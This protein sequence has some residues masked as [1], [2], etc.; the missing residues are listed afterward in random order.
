MP[1]RSVLGAHRLVAFAATA[2]PAKAKAFYKDTLGLRL[3]SD[4]QFAIVFDAAGTMLRVT[5]VDKVAV[6]PYTVL[7]WGVPDIVVTAKA[8]QKTGVTLQRY[9]GM[10]QDA[11]GIWTA[12]GGAKVGWFKD[13]DG[14]TLSITE[15]TD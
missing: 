10:D 5:I 12:P 1:R 4:D 7:G 13:P 15:Y 11:L 2:N 9:K 14:N 3:I 6:A 8:L